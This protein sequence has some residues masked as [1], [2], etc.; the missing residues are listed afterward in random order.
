MIRVYISPHVK[1]NI[2]STRLN[3]E[4]PEL[5][6]CYTLATGVAR[7]TNPPRQRNAYGTFSELNG[8]LRTEVATLRTGQ[9]LFL[10]SGL[11]Y[12]V[13]LLFIFHETLPHTIEV[14]LII[15]PPPWSRPH[16]ANH[17]DHTGN[18]RTRPKVFYVVVFS[19]FPIR[20]DRQGPHRGKKV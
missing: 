8:I 4:N 10:L 14:Y 12:G 6:K 5:V 18:I 7:A 1:K 16:T 19:S 3:V 2:Q 15:C 20:W 11:G 9:A 17:T 13:L